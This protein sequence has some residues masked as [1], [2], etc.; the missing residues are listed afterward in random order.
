[1]SPPLVVFRCDAGD[2]HGT[3]HVRRCLALGAVFRDAGWS[4][5]FATA[6]ETM[7]VV[8]EL[9]TGQTE[10]VLIDG[11]TGQRDQAAQVAAAFP[12]GVD[13]LVTDHYGLDA[14]FESAC[15]PFSRVLLALD[16]LAD[17]RRDADLLVD[18][19]LTR[20]ATDYQN[21]ISASC[22]VLTGPVFAPLGPDYAPRR[23][24]SLERRVDG[25]VRSILISLGGTDP[26]PVLGHVLDGLVKA[27]FD[28]TVTVVLGPTVARQETQRQQSDVPFRLDTAIAVTNMAE[29]L[30][31]TDLAIGAAGSS[32]WERCA[33][34]VPT[35]MIVTADNQQLVAS[36]LASSGAVEL[37]GWHDDVSVDLVSEAVRNLVAQPTQLHA[38]SRAASALC[39]GR[40]AERIWLSC[41]QK[42]TS[43]GQVSLRLATA[44]DTQTLFDWQV[45]PQTRRYAHASTPPTRDEHEAWMTEHLADPDCLLCLIGC[46][47]HDVGSIR[48]DRMNDGRD[49][50]VSIYLAPDAYGRGFAASALRLVQDLAPGWRLLAEVVA[51]NEAS[52]RLFQRVG[53]RRDPK[54][55]YVWEAAA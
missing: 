9:R 40:G 14:T 43:T 29:R 26:G 35:L 18:S 22:R 42:P 44:D 31:N 50:L 12:N 16:D 52:H 51:E 13:L 2:V 55:T 3:G 38:M 45:A 30:T 4:C 27:D 48:L 7:D 5:T 47:G 32:A 21:L 8:P 36:G 46:D 28:G 20:V 54:G 11:S 10:L 39:D 17:R 53:F 25:D 6:K 24:Q 33:L 23:R 37:L 15:R 41:Q 19:A 49:R 1:M 34:G